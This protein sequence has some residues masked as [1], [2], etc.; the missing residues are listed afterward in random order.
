[1]KCWLPF[2]VSFGREVNKQLVIGRP[3]T[4]LRLVY[5]SRDHIPKAYFDELE[6]LNDGINVNEWLSTS[7]SV[8]QKEK[9]NVSLIDLR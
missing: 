2:C 3:T 1:M 4:K 5:L 9:F 8:S 7:D 6:A